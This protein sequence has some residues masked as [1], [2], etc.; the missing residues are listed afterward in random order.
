MAEFATEP[1]LIEP[2]VAL[3]EENVREVF[4]DLEN[5]PDNLTYN[6]EEAEFT[7]SP[8]KFGFDEWRLIDYYVNRIPT[9]L[10]EQF[11]CLEYLLVDYW[12]EATKMTPLEEMEYRKNNA[13]NK[14]Q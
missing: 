1:Q 14:T 11:P 7:F 5:I 3:L 4:I 12:K 6:L 8:T 9:G 10:I 2:K 13:E